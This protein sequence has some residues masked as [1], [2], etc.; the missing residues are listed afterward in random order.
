VRLGDDREQ[1][2]WGNEVLS[3]NDGL[4]EEGT[5][6]KE[7]TVLFW[8]ITAKALPHEG[9]QPFAIATSQNNP[10]ERDVRIFQGQVAD[11]FLLVQERI[12]ERG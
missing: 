4:S 1:V 5:V 9:L 12:T 2:C 8:A 6:P 7:G 3:T 10:P 11:L